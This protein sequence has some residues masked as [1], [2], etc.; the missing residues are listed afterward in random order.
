MRKAVSPTPISSLDSLV[1]PEV[2]A[3]LSELRTSPQLRAALAWFRDQGH[4]RG[5]SPWLPV[6]SSEAQHLVGDERYLRY[7]WDSGIMHG[8]NELIVYLL[9]ATLDGP[10]TKR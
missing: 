5:P 10:D 1:P 4:L 2:G 3:C 8:Q 9:G 7:I 6:N